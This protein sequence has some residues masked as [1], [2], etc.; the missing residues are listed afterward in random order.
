MLLLGLISIL[1]IL[2]LPGIIVLWLLNLDKSSY[3]QKWLLV[4]TLSLFVNYVLVSILTLLSIYTVFIM[5][6]IMMFECGV[7]FY[8]YFTK[9]ITGIPN[10]SFTEQYKKLI[11]FFENISPLNRTLYFIAGL[12]ILFYVAL[13]IANIGTIFYFIDAVN[14]HAWN[15][16]A[17]E[18][19][20]NILPQKATH[21]PQLI[22]ANWSICYLLIGKADVHFF[23]SSNFSIFFSKRVPEV[24]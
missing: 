13:F 11:S 7:L 4:F 6:G 24:I 2:L 17:G 21:Y 15:S 18:F 23:C 8:L 5:G 3:I 1:Q 14:N 19:A 12:V 9:R 22:P 16:W 20:N 10:F